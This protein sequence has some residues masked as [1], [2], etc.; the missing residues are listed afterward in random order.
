MS[1]MIDRLK[2]AWWYEVNDDEACYAEEKKT[3]HQIGYFGGFFSGK[4]K[5]NRMT[6]M[7]ACGM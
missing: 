4:I 5:E 2:D 3:N 6:E 1:I 7:L